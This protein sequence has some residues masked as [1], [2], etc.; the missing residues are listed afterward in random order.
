MAIVV[1]GFFDISDFKPFSEARL[2]ITPCA[3]PNLQSLA[4]YYTLLH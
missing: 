3:N 2:S 4:Q 1:P